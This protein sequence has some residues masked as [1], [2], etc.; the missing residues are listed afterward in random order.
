MKNAAV[1]QIGERM[2]ADLEALRALA[3]E[4]RAKREPEAEAIE[5]AIVNLNS[6][7]DILTE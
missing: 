3:K 6:A 5:I 4:A 7:I 2:K 1:R